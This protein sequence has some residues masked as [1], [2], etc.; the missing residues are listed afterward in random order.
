MKRDFEH[1]FI[2][3][4]PVGSRVT[5]NP[6]P[7]DTDEDF[8]C[9]AHGGYLMDTE[10]DGEIPGK[11]ARLGFTAESC[12]SYTDDSGEHNSIFM[13]WRRG[14]TNLIVTQDEDFYNKF[15]VASV[16]A[17]RFNLLNKEDRISLFQAVLYGKNWF[18]HIINMTDDFV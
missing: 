15:L 8:L 10:G 1:L 5:C 12:A 17:K 18:N 4:E 7:T 9:M 3:V 11:L 16:L 6:A 14:E 2:S 13:S